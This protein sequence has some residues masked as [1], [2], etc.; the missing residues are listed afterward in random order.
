[1]NQKNETIKALSLWQPWA[2]AIACGAKRIET[3]HWSTKY[4]G[5]LAIHAAQT[6]QCSRPENTFTRRRGC[7]GG[8]SYNRSLDLK[9]GAAARVAAGI[10]AEGDLPHG[11]IIAVAD[12]VAC[13]PTR[14]G[15]ERVF[16]E[17]G[18]YHKPPGRIGL[19]VPP[20][21]LALGDFSRGRYGWILSNVRAL[22]E[23]IPYRG[24]QGLFD[25]PAELLRGAAR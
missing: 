16:Y 13:W 9:A 8:C 10:A 23:P 4:R 12:L 11:C 6:D 24:R 22:P 1:M 15:D 2:T 14:I 18:S 19:Q 25:V 7:V 3:R 5:P 17:G 20:S 21:E